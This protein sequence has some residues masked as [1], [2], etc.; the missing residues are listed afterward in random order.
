MEIVSGD[1]LNT[2]YGVSNDL[3]PLMQ[4]LT[5]REFEILELAIKGYSNK[6]I[7][8]KLFITVETVKSHRK[9]I[10]NKTGVSKVEEIKN[11]L[12]NKKI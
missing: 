1:S 10:V 8:E 2:H 6:L 5:K 3:L 4:H 9:S 11:W 12:L 7:S